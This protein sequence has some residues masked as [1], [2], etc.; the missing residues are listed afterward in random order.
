MIIIEHIIDVSSIIELQDS[1]MAN[2]WISNGW[3]L[4]N[5]YVTR[6]DEGDEVINF[7]LGKPN[8]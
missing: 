1:N 3:L 7:V 8:E 6:K 4:L 5:T 2:Q